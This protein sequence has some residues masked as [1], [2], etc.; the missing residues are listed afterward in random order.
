VCI[1]DIIEEV[2]SDSVH[3]TIIRAT[4]TPGFLYT[5]ELEV[6]AF[7]LNKRTTKSIG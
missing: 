3:A 4:V 5:Q 6:S 2:S 7:T 1:H